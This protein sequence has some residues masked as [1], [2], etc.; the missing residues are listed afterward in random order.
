MQV[1]GESK[2]DPP[3]SPD[4]RAEQEDHES[5]HQSIIS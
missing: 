4:E 3:E 1:A 2:Q 5:W